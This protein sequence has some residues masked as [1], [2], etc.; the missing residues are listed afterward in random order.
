MTKTTK[1]KSNTEFYKKWWFW[2]IVAFVGIGIVGAALG[3]GN[4][5][6]TFNQPQDSQEASSLKEDSSSEEGLSEDD[7]ELYCQ[8][9]NLASKFVDLNTIDIFRVMDQNDQ[10]G[11]FGWVDA[12]GNDVWY[13][14]W[15]GKDKNTGESVR[16]DCWV[17]GKDA[18]NINLHR[19][20]IGGTRYIDTV[21]STVFET[22]GQPVVINE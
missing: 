22:D 20:E 7:V 13:V 4:R 12:D 2:T 16:F 8:D 9:A 1:Q 21:S 11:K 19:Y 5:S 17:S 15:N 6:D 14:R 3:A 10:T 18:D